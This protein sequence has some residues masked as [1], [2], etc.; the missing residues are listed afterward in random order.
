MQQ[1]QHLKPFNT[2]NTW[3]IGHINFCTM[4]KKQPFRCG[5]SA[6]IILMSPSKLAARYWFISFI[7][8]DWDG[9]IV[10]P[11]ICWYG[12]ASWLLEVLNQ[13]ETKRGKFKI[14]KLRLGSSG[15]S[16]ER[17]LQLSVL[18]AAWIF[19]TDSGFRILKTNSDLRIFKIGSHFRILKTG[20]VLRILKTG[21][22]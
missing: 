18:S 4:S 13:F 17:K 8:R 10:H 12:L 7:S 22:D 20:F 5:M 3:E 11:R 9:A 14:H 19:K 21:S 1:Q 16:W 6:Q 2:F 15:A